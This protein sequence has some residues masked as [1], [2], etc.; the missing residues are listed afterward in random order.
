MKRSAA[1]VFTLAL[2]A[3]AATPTTGARAADREWQTGV[4]LEIKVTR[5]RVVIGLQPRPY[6]PGRQMPEMTEVRTYV[7]AGEDARFEVTETLPGG[8]RT[9]DALVGE[10]VVFAVTKNTLYVRNSDGTEHRLRITK[11]LSGAPR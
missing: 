8:R 7:I 6:G 2:A 10:K 3:S 9:I 5:P 4:W 11:R 1:L